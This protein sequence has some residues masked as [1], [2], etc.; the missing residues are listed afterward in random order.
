MPRAVATCS[1]RA[2]RVDGGDAL[3]ASVQ[4]SHSEGAVDPAAAKVAFALA[5]DLSER[6][7]FAYGWA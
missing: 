7:F 5:R 2:A 6:R 3:V 4:G 1:A